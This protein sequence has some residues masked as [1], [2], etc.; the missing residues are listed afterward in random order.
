MVRPRMRYRAQRALAAGLACLASGSIAIKTAESFLFP[1]E[2]LLIRSDRHT[3]ARAHTHTGIEIARG[4]D[5]RAKF[6]GVSLK[7][8]RVEKGQ[9]KGEVTV[10]DYVRDSRHVY[11]SCS[12]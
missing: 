5:N 10:L 8:L 2:S 3:R 1:G 9:I 11:R 6:D 12:R 7:G 4:T